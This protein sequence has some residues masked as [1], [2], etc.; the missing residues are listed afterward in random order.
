MKV[1][2][3]NYQ[4]NETL[5]I[6]VYYDYIFSIIDDNIEGFYP[7]L[8]EAELEYNEAGLIKKD[9]IEQEDDITLPFSR[10]FNSLCNDPYFESQHK[11]PEQ[12]STTD[13]GIIAK[14]YSKHKVICFVEAKRL[15][16]P[17]S[18]K[19]DHTEYVYCTPIK[20]G[21]IER[22]KTGRHAGK[23]K[24][25]ISIML[26]YIQSENANYWNTQINN[27]ISSQIL[28]SKNNQINWDINDKLIQEIDFKKD[29]LYKYCSSHSRI[30]LEPIKLVHYWIDLT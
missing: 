18:K 14:K 25:P 17:I 19:R 3:I 2:Q 30:N 5:P 24:L 11:T 21:G 8:K 7:F 15:P 23:E 22:Y 13:I 28:E 10:F 4:S 29:R 20:Q 12:N 16:T 1:P 9:E 26:G 27:W 6:E